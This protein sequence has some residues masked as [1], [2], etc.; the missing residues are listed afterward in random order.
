MFNS[1]KNLLRITLAAFTFGIIS[2][3]MA[4]AVY[5][6]PPRWAKAHGYH[7][8]R[9]HNKKWKRHKRMHRP[10][11]VRRRIVYRDRPNSPMNID[12]QVGGS[13]LGAILGAVTGS[14]L[15]KGNGKTVAILG[16]AVTGAI[17]G[18]KIGQQMS[19]A[20]RHQTANVLETTPTGQSVKWNNPD[21]GT[22]Y[23]V[24]PTRT[25]KNSQNLNCRDYTTWVFIDGYEEQVS[26]TACR[27]SDGNWRPET[28]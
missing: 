3:A 23:Q 2:T 16:G 15:G 22:D 21:T 13:I 5:A 14:Q 12:P 17:I 9:V 26:G 28:I 24:T 27:A 20:D 25:F 4:P 19:T 11:H 18:G 6:E 8:K 7:D 10:T 1:G